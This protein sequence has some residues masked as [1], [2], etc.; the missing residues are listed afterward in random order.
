MGGFHVLSAAYFYSFI[1]QSSSMGILCSS[2]AK[3]VILFKDVPEKIL[4]LPC[5]SCCMRCLFFLENFCSNFLPLASQHDFLSLFWSHSSSSPDSHIYS[6]IVPYRMKGFLLCASVELCKFFQFSIY[7]CF[8][9]WTECLHTLK[10]HMLQSM[11]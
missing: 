1:S 3:S 9:L 2:E 11:Q 5:C 8:V 4:S 7:V 6:M 10:I